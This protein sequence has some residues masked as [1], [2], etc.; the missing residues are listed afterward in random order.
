VVRGRRLFYF[1][2]YLPTYL[3]NFNTTSESEDRAGRDVHS[4]ILFA[5]AYIGLF[6][7][8]LSFIGMEFV[9]FIC[10]GWLAG[11]HSFSSSFLLRLLFFDKMAWSG[12]AGLGYPIQ[13]R[14]IILCFGCSLG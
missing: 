14:T 4:C 5:F 12:W 3:H 10:L 2:N 1:T 13:E 8:L 11:G 6:L 7:F 9:A